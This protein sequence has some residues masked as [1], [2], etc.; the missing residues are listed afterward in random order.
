M[1]RK[2]K[3]NLLKEEDNHL[4]IRI[5][6]DGFSF[7][8]KDLSNDL[9]A[10]GEVSFDE[11]ELL[12]VHHLEKFKEF[13]QKEELFVNKYGSI[14]VSHYNNL[15]TQVPLPF[16]KEESCKDYL[17][18]TV[19]VLEDDYVAFDKVTN[20]DLVNV[21][22]P[23]VHINNY[24]LDS[25]KSFT[26]KH[27]ATVLI[28]NLRHYGADDKCYYFVN[29]H[30][31]SMEVVV[32]KNHSLLLY[33]VFTY[34]TEEDFIYYLL[35]VAEQ[36]EINPEEF[37]LV[38]LGEIDEK[39]SYYKIASEYIRNVSFYQPKELPELFGKD[40]VPHRF[41]TLLHQ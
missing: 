37:F 16:F 28:E 4:S 8:V 13:F 3:N 36:L 30:K 39:S 10:I 41:F 25:Y 23:F 6:S 29:V 20:A 27:S 2:K 22:I 14:T 17:Q 12:P 18:Y 15:I 33:N 34:Q 35:F 9:L 19:K 11:N 40:I 7:C 5:S 31:G 1:L 26:F 21:Y 32:F 38:F 24:L